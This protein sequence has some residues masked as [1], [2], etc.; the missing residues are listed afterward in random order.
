MHSTE[1]LEMLLWLR[2]FLS[3]GNF[4]VSHRYY[5]STTTDGTLIRISCYLRFF[6]TIIWTTWVFDQS[7]SQ[8][9]DSSHPLTTVYTSDCHVYEM[10][11]M[12][13]HIGRKVRF[14]LFNILKCIFGGGGILHLGEVHYLII[15]SDSSYLHMIKTFLWHFLIAVGIP[16]QI[17]MFSPSVDLSFL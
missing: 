17:K 6:S 10:C 15:Q 2:N 5:F 3:D 14:P 1:E 12:H 13:K 11:C 8:N 7:V 16:S 9:K 4:S